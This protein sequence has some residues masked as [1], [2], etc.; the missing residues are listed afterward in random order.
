MLC[1]KCYLTVGIL[2][3]LYLEEMR[4]GEVESRGR[5]Q[6]I[7]QWVRCDVTNESRIQRQFGSPGSSA[8][9][10]TGSVLGWTGR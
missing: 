3:S 1:S 10:I 7:D 2:E 6:S 9:A 5:E 4:R 8:T